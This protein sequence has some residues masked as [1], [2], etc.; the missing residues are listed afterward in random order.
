MDGKVENGIVYGKNL[1]I[2]IFFRSY[3]LL[4]RNCTLILSSLKNHQ[5]LSS[6]LNIL[7]YFLSEPSVLSLSLLKAFHLRILQLILSGLPHM[8]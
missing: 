3:F 5:F 6:L 7:L 8:L 4:H 1:F 2:F